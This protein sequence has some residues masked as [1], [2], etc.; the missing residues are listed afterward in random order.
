MLEGAPEARSYLQ[1]AEYDRSVL[2][3]NIAIF[4]TTP[5]MVDGQLRDAHV[6]NAIAF[7]FDHCDNNILCVCII[8]K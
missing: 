6:F 8:S 3:P 1:Q 4:C 7:G 2:P 5:M